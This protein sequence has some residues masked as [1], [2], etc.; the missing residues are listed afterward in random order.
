VQFRVFE[1]ELLILTTFSYW[2]SRVRRCATGFLAL[3]ITTFVLL[4]TGAANAQTAIR[5]IQHASK[6]AG[7]TTSSTL[8]FA[9]NNTAGNFVAVVIRTAQTGQVFTVSDTRGNTYRQALQYNETVDATSLAVFYAENIAGGA[10][11]VTVS[12]TK[13]GTLR[14]AILEYSGVA[15]ANSLGGTAAGQGTGTTPTSGTTAAVNGD[16]ILGMISTANP[17]TFTAGSGFVVEE[18]VPAAPSTKLLVEDRLQSGTGAVAA[19]ATLAG[20]DVW[21]A[22]VATFH[23]ATSGSPSPADLTL[24]KTHVGTFAQGQTGATYTLTVTNI[25]AG[26]TS[27]TVTVTDTLPTGLTATGIAGAG[28]ACT[29]PARRPA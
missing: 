6:D 20:S 19:A 28:W 23:A 15:T 13:S 16:L 12:D 9:A 2:T 4:G 29:Q 5:L 11:T 10:N 24:A 22:A 27:G 18:R 26:A 14:F 21:G 25:G 3:A 8:A 17:A 7:T 1:K